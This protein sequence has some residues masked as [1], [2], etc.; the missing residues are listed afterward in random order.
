MWLY[1]KNGWRLCSMGS[2]ALASIL[3]EW[4]QSWVCKLLNTCIQWN[5]SSIGLCNDFPSHLP[6]YSWAMPN[7]PFLLELGMWHVG[8]TGPSQQTC[9]CVEW[10][11]LRRGSY[12]SGWSTISPKSGQRPC[13]TL[14]AKTNRRQ[15]WRSVLGCDI[16]NKGVAIWICRWFCFSFIAHSLQWRALTFNWV[17]YAHLWTLLS[18]CVI[19]LTVALLNPLA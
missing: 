19:M 3:Q 14:S 4:W 7:S 11:G 16:L 8:P 12:D 2:E 10:E 1:V 6:L 9:A 17:L 15:C 18:V 13:G 5:G